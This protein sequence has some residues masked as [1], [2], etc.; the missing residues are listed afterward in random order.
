MTF[1]LEIN[2]CN[3]G[4]GAVLLQ[5]EHSIAY[6]SQKLFVLHQ[7][8]STYSKELWAIMESIHKWRHYL[9]G[10]EFEIRTD[11]RSLH[12]LLNQ[13]IQS[14]EQQYF[15][16]RLL[17]SM[18]TIVYR[19]GAGENHAADALSRLSKQEEEDES[20]LNLLTS[21]PDIGWKT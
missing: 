19:K 18:Y 10:N 9:L 17:G 1:M 4:I 12:N 2:A 3:V 21:Q 16:T 7:K 14:P 15:L 11:H 8:A 6:F 20:T 5:W 13:A